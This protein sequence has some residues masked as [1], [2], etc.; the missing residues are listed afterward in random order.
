MGIEELEKQLN[1]RRFIV[2]ILLLTTSSLLAQQSIIASH[3]ELNSP[4]VDT[5]TGPLTENPD[6]DA[7][8]RILTGTVTVTIAANSLTATSAI[9]FSTAFTSA[10]TVFITPNG[11]DSAGTLDVPVGNVLLY[12]IEPAYGGTWSAFPS[13]E[14]ELFGQSVTQVFSRSSFDL[15]KVQT[16]EFIVNCFEAQSPVGT[17]ELRPQYSNDGGTTWLDLASTGGALDLSVAGGSGSCQNG[18]QPQRTG[19]ISIAS[20]AKTAIQPVMIRAVGMGGDDAFSTIIIYRVELAFRTQVI[21]T[22]NLFPTVVTVNGFTVNLRIT[23]AVT[24]SSTIS[25]RWTA[26]S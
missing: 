23:I 25:V 2:G 6:T 5:G 9:T 11:A 17:E 12:I 7:V 24:S 10:P 3:Q 21:R 8:S 20:G 14:T 4:G 15:N 19:F 16:A 22:V 26:W 1:R 13:A 18:V